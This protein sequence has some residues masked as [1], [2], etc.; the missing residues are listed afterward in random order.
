M[1]LRLRWTLVLSAGA[2]LL[3]G[4]TGGFILH[5]AQQ[6]ERESDTAWRNERAGALQEGLRQWSRVTAAALDDL[7][8]SPRFGAFLRQAV[9]QEDEGRREV[10]LWAERFAPRFGLELLIV[11]DEDG[12]ILSQVPGPEAH[13]IVHPHFPWF[14]RA[15]PG[16]PESGVAVWPG[17][18]RRTDS[19]PTLERPWWVGTIRRVRPAGERSI[20]V[21]GARELSRSVQVDLAARAG[22][23]RLEM[24]LEVGGL[25]VAPLPPDWRA[26]EPLP[27][28]FDPGPS[29]AAGVLRDLRAR[30]SRRLALG[31]VLVL[32]LTPWVAAGLTRPVRRLQDAVSRMR[33]GERR[34]EL[35]TRGPR[36]LRELSEALVQLSQELDAIQARA[37]AQQRQAAWGGMARRVAHEL[38]NALSPLTLALDNVETAALSEPTEE[39]REDL[40]KSLGT[41][42]EQLASLDRLVRGFRDFARMPPLAV[43]E[44]DARALAAAAVAAVETAF[45]R[46]RFVV[47]ERST[48]GAIEADGEQLRR[49][50]QNLLQN[51][52][53]ASLEG[54]VELTLGAG[55]GPGQ[56]W[57]A[58]GDR[59]P[60]LPEEIRRHWGEAY[61]TTKAEGTG[62]GLAIARQVIEAHGGRLDVQDRPRGGLLVRATLPRKQQATTV[63]R[64]AS[65]RD[66]RREDRR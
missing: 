50:M 16:G 45:D 11:L 8:G 64:P 29:P 56:W 54:V 51:A 5:Q 62:L 14:T 33:A 23:E 53:E 10:V 25:Q 26:M 58:V 59:G 1:S 43:E 18:V 31:A 37:E 46:H 66:P 35:K 32:L 49:V 9:P 63:S 7:V 41:A 60:G 15:A 38:K 19:A 52:A 42:R 40:R 44:V 13:G 34:L 24:G 30:L 39:M 47:E 48:V 27:L 36:E 22:L 4:V 65:P 57:F 20:W 6:I 3:L 17:W 61:R 12:R 55:P 28:V 21:V 2:L